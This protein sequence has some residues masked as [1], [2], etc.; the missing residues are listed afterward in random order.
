MDNSE[1]KTKLSEEQ[2]PV[3]EKSCEE[4]LSLIKLHLK[5]EWEIL[6]TFGLQIALLSGGLYYIA[7]IVGR[8]LAFFRHTPGPPLHD[9]GFELIPEAES[10]NARWG[11]DGVLAMMYLTLVCISVAAVWD[12]VKNGAVSLA[13]PFFVNIWK[14]H[15]TVLVI[16]HMLRIPTYLSTSLP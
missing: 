7:M 2:T 4:I 16:G 8:N 14:R 15:L 3:S 10:Y 6:S 11:A 1:T 9:L 13:G 12:T 5:A